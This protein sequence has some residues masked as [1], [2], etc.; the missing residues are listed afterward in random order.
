MQNSKKSAKSRGVLVFAI[1]SKTVDYVAIADNTSRLISHNLQLPITLVTD[2]TGAPEFPY[3]SVIRISSSGST[4]RHTSQETKVEWKN[5]DRYLAEQLSPYNETILVDT[6]Y[7]VLDDSLL[8]LFDTEFDYKLMHYNNT[9]DGISYSEMGVASLPYVWATVVLF[10]KTERAKLFFNLV[11]RVQRNYDYYRSLY[12][13]R[14]GNYRNDYA[15]AIANC[16][17]SGYTITDTQGIPWPMFTVEKDIE[18]I[19]LSDQFLKVCHGTD[20]VVVPYS[21]IHIMDKKYLQSSDFTQLVRTIC[22]PI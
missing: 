2:E 6:D 3:D 15:F 17:L 14:E 18:K 19:V 1:N 4:Y 11:G 16:I 21:N 22:E 9:A 12:N 20:A 7:L 10:R 8:K 5:F 13:V